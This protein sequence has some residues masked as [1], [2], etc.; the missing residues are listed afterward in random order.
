VTEF[1][2]PWQ[3]PE[4]VPANTELLDEGPFQPASFGAVTA[5][6]SVAI[7]E[8]SGMISQ[9]AA[10]GSG[11][12]P[13]IWAGGSSTDLSSYGFPTSS[14]GESETTTSE[15]DP[16]L[17]V[18][19]QWLAQVI[20]PIDLV[21][22]G[23]RRGD[24][25]VRRAAAGWVDYLGVIVGD[26]VATANA[27][28]AR[29]IAVEA[30]GPGLY[31]E[32]AEV[33][34]G[35]TAVQ[36]TARRID[37]PWSHHPPGQTIYRPDRGRPAPSY[38]NVGPY[39]GPVNERVAD[40]ENQ[41]TVSALASAPEYSGQQSGLGEDLTP[42]PD[43]QPTPV[44]YDAAAAVKFARK[45]WNRPCPDL[46]ISPDLNGPDPRLKIRGFIDASRVVK[47]SKCNG[48]EEIAVDNAGQVVHQ[49]TW[50]FLDD[51]T[52]FISCCIGRPPK[53]PLL[54]AANAKPDQIAK[55]RADIEA[56]GGLELPTHSLD[57]SM[58][59]L[60]GADCLIEFLTAPSR[61]W[62]KVIAEAKTK[63]EARSL[64][65]QML[66]GDLIAYVGNRLDH[67]AILLGDHG[68]INGK[69]ACH[70]YCRSDHPDCTWD[71]D[72]DAIKPPGGDYRVT[73]LQMPRTTP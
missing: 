48:P 38:I 31:V 63:D 17:G 57:E 13:L 70:T 59:G 8:A 33:P 6:G 15:V 64:M 34:L 69:V 42:Q 24:L 66:P 39:R 23:L 71:N 54:N 44:K 41:M 51:C 12:V 1:D 53:G 16:A 18:G 28:V 56:A 73:L 37:D 22:H 27:F 49:G 14:Y 45:Y 65:D 62:A 72:W 55:W 21:R 60:S 46:R 26:Y 30:A 10:E 5:A 36:F 61:K 40:P 52:H 7:S 3:Q 67:L 68:K 43:P 58:Y 4:T 32:V 50:D 9:E 47:F 25:L 2:I 19:E 20:D 35:G 11:Q 29:G